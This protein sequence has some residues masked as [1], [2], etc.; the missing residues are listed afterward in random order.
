MALFSCFLRR[1]SSGSHDSIADSF[2]SS[3]SFEKLYLH[4]DAQTSDHNLARLGVAQAVMTP[5]KGA[6]TD[7]S[8]ATTVIEFENDNFYV[9]QH[10][11]EVSI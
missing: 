1:D 10:L 2:E 11:P 6:T 9:V 4:P 8:S 3:E 7:A 5:S